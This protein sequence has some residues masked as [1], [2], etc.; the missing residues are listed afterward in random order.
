MT[1]ADE[2][3]RSIREAAGDV[4]SARERA[5]QARK[6]AAAEAVR[7]LAQQ[8]RDEDAADSPAP[9]EDAGTWDTYADALERHLAAADP[10]DGGD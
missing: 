4:P 6:D 7:D 2:W 3:N 9:P 5:L 8:K 10:G 1:A